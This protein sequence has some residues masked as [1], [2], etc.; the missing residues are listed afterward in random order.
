MNSVRRWCG[1]LVAALL[2]TGCSAS[3][4]VGVAQAEV[5]HFRQLMT[6]QQFGRVYSEGSDELKKATT[7]QAMVSL[8]SAVHRKLGGVKR[9]WLERELQ[10]DG[11][12][13][14]T[15]VQDAV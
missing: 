15:Q 7:E 4:D 5:E 10:A 3:Q 11:E 6:E 2:V 14:D 1:L 13:R 9:K 12:F 8:L